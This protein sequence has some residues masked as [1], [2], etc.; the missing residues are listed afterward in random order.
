[1]ILEEAIYYRMANYDDLEDLIGTRI[2]PG[3]IPQD[4]E[5]PAIAYQRIDHETWLTHGGPSGLAR[6][7]VQITIAAEEYSDLKDVSDAVRD[8][9]SGYHGLVGTTVDS[10]LI[11]LA[12]VGAYQDIA[13][14]QIDRIRESAIGQTIEIDIIHAE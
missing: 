11:S 5:L 12:Q 13:G 8:C 3:A 14:Q 10:L 4:A 7:V 9:W 1:M 2:Y 6:S